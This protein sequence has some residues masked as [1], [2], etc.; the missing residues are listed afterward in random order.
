MTD[1][2][3]INHTLATQFTQKHVNSLINAAAA[4]DITVNQIGDPVD[5]S[6]MAQSAFVNSP[7]STTVNSAINAGSSNTTGVSQ[8]QSGFH[9]LSSLSLWLQLMLS[10]WSH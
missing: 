2:Q 7:A 5:H 3:T 4:N 9:P 1:E 6:S 8:Q 10:G